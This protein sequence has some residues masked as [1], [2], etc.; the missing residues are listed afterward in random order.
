MERIEPVYKRY[1]KL[2]QQLLKDVPLDLQRS[3]LKLN[4]DLLQ[5]AKWGV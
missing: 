4:E 5:K 1:A 2:C 3:A